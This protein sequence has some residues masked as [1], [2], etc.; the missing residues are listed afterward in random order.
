MPRPTVVVTR[1][2]GQSRQLTEALSAAGLDVLGFPLL[3]IGPAADEGRLRAALARL[4]D[5]SLVVFVSP[6]AVAFALEALA[7]V[8]DRPAPQWPEA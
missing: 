2:A 8:Q 5:F 6:N 1:P 3:A 4:A 7:Q